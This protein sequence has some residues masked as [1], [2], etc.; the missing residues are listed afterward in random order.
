MENSDA[1]VELRSHKMKVCLKRLQVQWT[2]L[3]NMAFVCVEQ[4]LGKDRTWKMCQHLGKEG[5]ALLAAHMH[6]EDHIYL[7]VCDSFFSNPR[8]LTLPSLHG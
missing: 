8:K 2:S 1:Y 4:E 3:S 5:E 7:M 6:M